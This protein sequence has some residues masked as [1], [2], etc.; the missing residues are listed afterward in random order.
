VAFVFGSKL[1]DDFTAQNE[2]WKDCT[3]DGKFDGWAPLQEAITEYQ[4][5]AKADKITAIQKELDDTTQILVR[6]EKDERGVGRTE[7]E[8]RGCAC[9]LSARKKAHR[10]DCY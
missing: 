10:P 6:R 9:V 5:P 4:D 2:G 3:D 1:L 8:R 7:G